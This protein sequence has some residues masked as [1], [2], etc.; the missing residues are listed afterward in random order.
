[1]PKDSPGRIAYYIGWEIVND[2]MENNPR[3]T[4]EALMQNT[5]SQEILQQSGY[6]P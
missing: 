1:M 2:Y 6:K 5:E 3:L 4:L